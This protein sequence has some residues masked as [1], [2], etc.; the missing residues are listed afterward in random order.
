M[1]TTLRLPPELQARLK[2]TAAREHRS[3]HAVIVE[4]I[5]R[6]T[7]DRDRRR[8]IALARVLERDQAILDA[9]A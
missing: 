2:E 7:A 9:L 5:E 1:A 6:Y 3:E 8:D 4:A